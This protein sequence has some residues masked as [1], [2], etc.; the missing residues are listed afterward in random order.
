MRPFESKIGIWS[1]AEIDNENDEIQ[2]F[3]GPVEIVKINMGNSGQNGG[4]YC[5]YC[6]YHTKDLDDLKKHI[7]FKHKPTEV[8]KLRYREIIKI[9]L[10]SVKPLYIIK[11]NGDRSDRSIGQENRG[12]NTPTR[13][14]QTLPKKVGQNDH[15][16][17]AAPY[18]LLPGLPSI[19]PAVRNISDL[20]S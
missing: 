14:H 20:Q 3:H 12:I 10:S 8:S 1:V 19:L 15:W 9:P 4:L 5:Q 2:S 6:V 7:L 13:L 17:Y 16:N 18:S 11:K